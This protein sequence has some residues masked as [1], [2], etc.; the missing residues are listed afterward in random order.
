MGVGVTHF[1]A[2]DGAISCADTV[3]VQQIPFQDL[4]GPPFE[5]HFGIVLGAT[6]F[7]VAWVHFRVQFGGIFC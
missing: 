4:F 1:C 5:S 3:P 7:W 6:N 2:K